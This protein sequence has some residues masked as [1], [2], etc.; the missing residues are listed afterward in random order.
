MNTIEHGI[1]AG[2]LIF[3][4]VWIDEALEEFINNLSLYKYEEDEKNG[5]FKKSPLHDFASHDADAFRYMAI[6]YE[7]LTKLPV[8][9][10]DN[11]D[12]PNLT[13][14]DRM[15]KEMEEEDETDEDE[16]LDSAY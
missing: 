12:D 11:D 15:F 6:V 4:H 8:S 1:S 3:K 10:R 16:E 13:V 9:E 5:V 7:F 14:F 2:R